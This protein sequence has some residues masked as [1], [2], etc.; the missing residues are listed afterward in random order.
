M[1]IPFLGINNSYV[2]DLANVDL[3]KLVYGKP[4]VM[5]DK[6]SYE[7]IVTAVK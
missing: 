5:G 3:D 6:S 4:S 2:L 1:I 7:A